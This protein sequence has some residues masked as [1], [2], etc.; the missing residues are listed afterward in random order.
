VDRIE[1]YLNDLLQ[2]KEA[3]WQTTRKTLQQLRT[4]E[5]VPFEHNRP[6]TILRELA[7]LKNSPILVD[8]HGLDKYQLDNLLITS[9][10][11]GNERD[12]YILLDQMLLY[13]K[14]PSKKV[15]NELLHFLCCRC[16]GSNLEKLI[17]LCAC[18]FRKFFHENLKF[19][20]YQSLLLWKQGDSRESLKIFREILGGC[21]DL[22][23]REAVKDLICSIVDETIG[24]KS[25]GV[26]IGLTE[27]GK[28]LANTFDDYHILMKIWK[29][30]F[31]SIWFSD[32]QMAE[33]LF[34][35]DPKIRHI[36]VQQASFLSFMYLKEH[37][38]EAVH[39]L[40]ELFLKFQMKAECLNILT[41]LFD[42]HCE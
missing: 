30:C 38:L 17:D 20:H 36:V 18:D 6:K 42:Y 28:Y 14:L 8:I 4:K 34:E 25:E 33:E 23:I 31:K 16:D 24:N 3:K 37:N 21:Q 2:T 15:F 13:R 32:N 5:V 40:I 7:N 27:V 10:D 22:E 39:R 29:S 12:L 41:V 11:E 26:L 19:R 1:A 35:R 9:L